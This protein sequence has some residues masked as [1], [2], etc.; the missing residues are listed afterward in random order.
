VTKIKWIENILGEA[1]AVFMCSSSCVKVG[2]SVLRN[3]SYARVG[4][5]DMVDISQI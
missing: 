4:P 3:V 5:E 2:G 1:K